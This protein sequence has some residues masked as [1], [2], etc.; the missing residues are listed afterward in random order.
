M[1]K[2]VNLDE[3]S[4]LKY[5]M[6]MISTVRSRTN[7]IIEDSTN[8]S[9]WIKLDSN[10]IAEG[11]KVNVN[12]SKRKV[13]LEIKPPLKPP[14]VYSQW[15]I[16]EHKGREYTR[17]RLSSHN[18]K[19]ETGRW[20]RTPR[21]DGLCSC[22]VSKQT[23]EH[24]LLFCHETKQV[25]DKYKISSRNITELYELEDHLVVNFVYEA[26]TKMNL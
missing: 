20:C 21:E 26:I 9:E 5:A 10:K 2:T 25:R 16:S 23:E 13:Y 11:I 15:N 4:L 18:L 12:S 17:T 6:N 8:I 19:I 24:V 7:E 3:E 14:T 22:K 1:R